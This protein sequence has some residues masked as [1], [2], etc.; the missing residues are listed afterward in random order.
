MIVES[1][2]ELIKTQGIAIERGFA[3]IEIQ[4]RCLAEIALDGDGAAL[5]RDVMK[6]VAE[7]SK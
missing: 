7:R 5:A 1:K 3:L 4:N 2:D 6:I